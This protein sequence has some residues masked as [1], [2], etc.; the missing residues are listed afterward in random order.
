M[1]NGFNPLTEK[2]KR[3]ARI[4]ATEEKSLDGL[5]ASIRLFGPGDELTFAGDDAGS[6]PVVVEGLVTRV[7]RFDDNR[8]QITSFLLPGDM[9]DPNC[10]SSNHGRHILRAVASSRVAIVP[11]SLIE[12]TASGGTN[13]A[14]AFWRAAQLEGAIAREWL[15]ML[16]R[17]DAITRTAHLICEL[18]KR[19]ELVGLA[20]QNRFEMPLTQRLLADVLGLSV[21]HLNRTMRRLQNDGLIRIRHALIEVL[22]VD[23]LHELAGFDPAYLYWS[24]KPV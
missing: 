19:L 21:V 14:R 17:Q 9:C 5:L 2:L 7:R 8:Q 12:D 24:G 3:L 20:D 16:G 10:F 13:L 23:R 11:A 15:V 6:L 22:D 18:H 4:S 1:S